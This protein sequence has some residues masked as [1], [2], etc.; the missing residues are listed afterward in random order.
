MK[1]IEAVVLAGGL[2]SRFGGAKLLATYR[3]S[4]LI[5]GALRAAAAAPVGRVIVVTGY[6]GERV[7]DAVNLFAAGGGFSQAWEVVY[8]I[9]YGEGMAATLRAG[10]V[11]VSSDADGVLIFLG[12]MPNLRSDTAAQLVAA[13]GERGAAAPLFNGDRGH[14]V[15]VAARHLPALRELKGDRGAR[16]LLETLGDDFALVDVD[17]P[18]VIFD[19]DHPWDIA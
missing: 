5:A 17:D 2:G 16:G 10:V 9:G 15:L 14:P 19:V 3:G 7:K 13:V 6:D 1:R 4:P 18:G 8:A 12:D 11:A